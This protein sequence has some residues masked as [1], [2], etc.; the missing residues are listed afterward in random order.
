MP[1]VI[2]A[3]AV[4]AAATIYS[5]YKSGQSSKN[6]T[7]AQTKANQ[8]AMDWEKQKEAERK[9]EWD[10]TQAKKEAAYNAWQSGRNK[11]LQERLGFS[12]PSSSYVRQPYDSS[13]STGAIS[14]L[15]TNGGN[16]AANAAQA[17]GQRNAALAGSLGGIAASAIGGLGSGAPQ[18]YS[19]SY[20]Q[21]QA[22]QP[23]AGTDNPGGTQ[24]AGSTLGQL[25]GVQP[26][27]GG[28]VAPAAWNDWGGYGLGQ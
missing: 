13:A 2:I 7:N 4:A 22:A 10:T 27:P 21:N 9:A 19:G 6:A 16:I 25:A 5:S 28:D 1:P 24:P 11:F 17:S 14:G 18:E 8:Q 3:A 12:M 23:T 26:P 15:M 20:A